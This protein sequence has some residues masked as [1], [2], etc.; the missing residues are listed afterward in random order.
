MISAEESVSGWP[1]RIYVGE[2]RR[3]DLGMPSGTLS[4]SS[5]GTLVSRLARIDIVYA[6]IPRTIPAAG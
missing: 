3:D 5:S 6:V 1:D 4:W 2:A